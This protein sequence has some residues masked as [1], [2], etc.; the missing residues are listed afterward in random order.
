[1]RYIKLFEEINFQP[2]KKYYTKDEGDS[3]IVYTF[4]YDEFTF[5]VEFNKINDEWRRDFHTMEKGFESLNLST[6]GALDI[7]SYVTKITEDFINEYLPKRLTINHTTASRFKI[8]WKFINNMNI[9]KDY[10]IKSIG[11]EK[12]IISK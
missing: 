3:I 11:T 12:T 2:R 5:L 10:L 8:N 6:K 9:S 4:D 7:F 1:M